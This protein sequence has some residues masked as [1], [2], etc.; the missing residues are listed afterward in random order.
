[1]T[2][3]KPMTSDEIISAALRDLDDWQERRD[4]IVRAAVT[5]YAGHGAADFLAMQSA[6]A[7]AFEEAAR[8]EMQ[9]FGEGLSWCSLARTAAR[10]AA[11]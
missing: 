1:M 9:K 11:P 8:Q 6:L 2:P 10:L 3:T 7:A 4:A 5:A